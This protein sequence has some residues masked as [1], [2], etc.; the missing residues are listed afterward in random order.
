MNK[1]E[2]KQILNSELEKFR[3]KTYEE[4]KKSI[5]K[6]LAYNINKS[7]SENYQI[8]IQFFWDDKPDEDIRVIGS[9]DNGRGL[10]TFIPMTNSFIKNSSNNFVDE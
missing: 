5:N 9:I 10:S 6:V 3:N 7:D 8:E 4:L 2:A 1:K